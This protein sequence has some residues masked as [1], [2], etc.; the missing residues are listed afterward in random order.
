MSCD[1]SRR[2]VIL[3][4][5]VILAYLTPSQ[6]KDTVVT[7]VWQGDSTVQEKSSL[8]IDDKKKNEHNKSLMIAGAFSEKTS[9]Y[10]EENNTEVSL[11]P[12]WKPPIPQPTTLGLY[13]NKYELVHVINTRFM[14]FQPDLTSLGKARLE[15]F[16]TFTLPSILQQTEQ[17][18]LWIVWMDPLL[19]TSLRQDFLNLV[20]NVTNLV[21]IGS[22]AKTPFIRSDFFAE[23][24]ESSVYAGSFPLL[25][26]YHQAALTRTVLHTEL[27]SDD[28][29]FYDF[30]RGLQRRAQE[31]LAASTMKFDYR[32]FCV[33]K[34]LE[35]NYY[36]PV[37]W[38]LQQQQPDVIGNQ[39]D[40][41]FLIGKVSK[42]ECPPGG[43][44]KG[45][46]PA[47]DI[48][49]FP[50]ESR[51]EVHTKTPQCDYIT[52]QCIDRI[53]GGAAEHAVLRSRTPTSTGMTDVVP[54][55]P[56]TEKEQQLKSQLQPWLKL[57][58]KLW[59]AL[60]KNFGVTFAA[61]QQVRQLLEEDM[62]N[63]VLQNL[64]GQCKDG[65]SCKKSTKEQL[66]ALKIKY[67]GDEERS[68]VNNFDGGN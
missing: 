1:C 20:H 11:L 40:V 66:K 51:F 54:P 61:V 13:K 37:V 21:V 29:L 47:T 64:E 4:C 23:L 38:Q 31:T 30:V 12:S 18:F 36:D 62:V 39:T 33:S 25:L 56:N 26:D 60:P 28:A 59:Q 48:T 16:R 22:R 17:E 63:I 41:G 42:K 43:F 57:Q 2:E 32:F 58:D 6:F 15:L 3:V 55:R 35:W 27:D 5:L 7:L 53:N 49:D 34:R 19:D 8:T 14:Q 24:F 45:F 9:P 67:K 68:Y 10:S 50:D 44:T 52:H 46:G 65:F